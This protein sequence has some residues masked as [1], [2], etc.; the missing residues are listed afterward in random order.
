MKTVMDRLAF[1]AKAGLLAGLLM[2][3]QQALAQDTQAGTTITNQATVSFSVNNIQQAAVPSNTYEFEVDRRVDFVVS[4]VDPTL[5]SINPNQ[6]GLALQFIVT[7]E[8]NDTLDFSLASR[9]LA[10]AEAFGPGGSL[11]ASGETMSAV[12]IEVAP[13]PI[14]SGG[15]EDPS[16]GANNNSID[17]LAPGEQIRVWI[18][19]DAPASLPDLAVP[20][21]ELS[22]TALRSDGVALTDDSGD[23]DDPA[24]VQNVFVNST[25]TLV[26]ADGYTVAS[27]AVTADKSSTVISDPFGGPNPKAIPNAVVEYTIVVTNNG[28]ATATDISISDTLI[29][30]LVQVD[31]AVDVTRS[32]LGPCTINVAA[33]CTMVAGANPGESLLTI[34]VSD[35]ASGQSE[36]ISFRVIVQ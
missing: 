36:T 10:N 11:S 14:G 9:A 32:A 8:S 13:D 34:G 28:S 4:V 35:L 18:F 26:E 19:S 3:G 23:A 29:D 21:L 20:A 27:A 24:T 22:A 17:D 12:T 2:S 31:T 15:T 33:D 5:E 30:A 1:L 6:P 16:R 7:N 25:D